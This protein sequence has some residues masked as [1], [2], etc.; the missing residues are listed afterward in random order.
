MSV[1]ILAGLSTAQAQT[2]PA[3]ELFGGGSHCQAQLGSDFGRKGLS[4]WDGAAAFTL[5]RRFDIV[6]QFGGL[7]GN[8]EMDDLNVRT[9]LHS[10]LFGVRFRP[11]AGRRFSPF[12]HVAGGPTRIRGELAGFEQ[13]AQADLRLSAVAGGGIDWRTDKRWGLRLIQVDWLLTNSALFDDSFQR[14]L[15]LSAGVLIYPFRH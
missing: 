9:S 14:H 5:S 6:A 2:R 11:L 12:G 7:Y 10:L 15:R 1:I 13:T 8:P 3:F 4:G